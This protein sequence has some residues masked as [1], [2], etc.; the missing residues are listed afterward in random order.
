MCYS[1]EVSGGTFAFVA[2]ISLYLWMRDAAQD[3]PTALILLV[4]ASMQL[5]ELG[6]WLNLDCR[7]NIHKALSW[8]IN[9]VLAL[10]PILI[11][12]IIYLFNAGRFSRNTYLFIAAAMLP[13]LGII[14][15]DPPCVKV[16]EGSHLEWGHVPN[17]VSRPLTYLY[18]FGLIF[19]FL[20]FKNT[21]FG[22]LYVIF[23]AVTQF[24]LW[25]IYEN[26]WPSVWCHFVNML[27]LL[28]L[29]KN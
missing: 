21:F 25:V 6:L 27:A 8:S 4:I 26:A 28:A 22:V 3:R 24:K 23:S 18:H 5:I 19:L 10:Q 1:P 13:V 2:V 15:N 11:A 20:S 7:T 16:G 17:T 9:L 12:L 14:P 29:V